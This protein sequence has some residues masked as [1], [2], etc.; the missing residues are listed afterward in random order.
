M[1]FRTDRRSS[2]LRTCTLYVWPCFEIIF[3]VAI[4]S[5]NLVTIFAFH[6]ALLMNALAAF[7]LVGSL[8]RVKWCTSVWLITATMVIANI[9]FV[10][11]GFSVMY[12]DLPT[13]NVGDRSVATATYAIASF[14]SICFY[15]FAMAFVGA[16]H[17]VTRKRDR[18]D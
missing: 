12:H 4:L 13:R 6:D 16:E 14:T 8:A 15:W 5:S 18:R 7:L 10:G 3:A 11:R 2:I 17:G 9:L 1:P